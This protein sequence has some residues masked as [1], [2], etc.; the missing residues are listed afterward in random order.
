MMYNSLFMKRLSDKIHYLP[1]S[2]LK[3]NLAFREEIISFFHTYEEARKEHAFCGVGSLSGVSAEQVWYLDLSNSGLRELPNE[4]LQCGGLRAL[5]LSGNSLQS[6]DALCKLHRLE[7]LFLEKCQLDRLPEALGNLKSLF[8]LDLRDNRL[9]TLPESIAHLSRLLTLNLGYNRLKELSPA[10]GQLGNLLRL[11]VLKNQ[12]RQL[13][14]SLG[15]LQNLQL[16][17]IR[18]NQLSAL[19]EAITRLGALTY[20]NAG[21]NRL[22]ALP[23]GIHELEHLEHLYINNNNLQGLPTGLTKL[24]KLETIYYKD[25]PFGEMAELRHVGQLKL[26]TYLSQVSSEGLCEVIWE[27]P[28][29]LQT[30]FQQYLV[31]FPEFVERQSGRE[32]AFQV[33][34]VPEGLKLSAQANGTLRLKDINKYLKQYIDVLKLNQDDLLEKVSQIT[35]D[36]QKAFELRQLIRE[37]SREKGNLINKVQ[38]HLEKIMI[39]SDDRH[40]QQEQISSL[41]FHIRYFQT[42]S[43]DLFKLVQARQSILPTAV[44]IEIMDGAEIF[45]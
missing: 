16:L 39:L 24:Q 27:V 43:S 23:E 36:E 22:K 11:R 45:H 8:I 7:V 3:S 33:V 18:H 41:N 28:K 37:V 31:Y 12:L 38:D 44:N 2:V 19:P 5:D 35:R 30:A 20:L 6:L 21:H 10:V 40:K 42:V 4:V 1:D 29:A 32:I 13:P 9:S 25:N 15:E 26:F 34:R 14:E 17:D